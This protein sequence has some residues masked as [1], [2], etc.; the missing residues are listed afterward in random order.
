MRQEKRICAL[1]D[2]VFIHP[3]TLI[4]FTACL[5]GFIHHSL[6]GAFLRYLLKSFAFLNLLRF[7]DWIIQGA[8]ASGL[9]KVGKAIVR[10]SELSV[11]FV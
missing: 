10:V 9:A 1:H 3:P 11:F 8:N 2:N 7:A 4:M 6:L 5:G